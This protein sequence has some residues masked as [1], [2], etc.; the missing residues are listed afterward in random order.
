[1][2]GEV[3]KDDEPNTS[4]EVKASEPGPLLKTKSRSGMIVTVQTEGGSGETNEKDSDSDQPIDWSMNDFDSTNRSWTREILDSINTI[5]FNVGMLVNNSRVQVLIVVLIVINAIMMGIATYDI[6]KKNPEVDAIFEMVDEIFLIIFTVELC[7]QFIYLGWRLPLDGWLL[8]DLI[9]I[10]TSWS[11]ASV[12]IIRA[13]RIF[14]ALRLVTRIKIMKNLLL[15]LFSVMPRMAAIGLM[16]CLIL[17]IFA[18][19]CTQLFKDLHS[20]GLTQF[21]YFGNM[22]A[23]L[24]TLFQMMTLDG[25]GGICREV[26]AVHY[27]AWIPIIAYVI[28]SGFVVVNLIIAVICDAISALGS[29]E[30]AKLEGNYDEDSD[31]DSNS[32]GLEIRAQ[33]DSLEQ[34][35]ED[36]TRIQSRSFH[37]LNYLTKQIEARKKYDEEMKKDL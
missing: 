4:V 18:V 16:L 7:L 36:L 22:F 28:I 8:F 27:W 26:M 6:V 24:L 12:Q 17:Y 25:W 20:K 23:T 13:F 11:F 3:E 32:Q 2:N 34:Q 1:M 37:A 35:M 10:V 21:D 5:R 33:L 29:D 31:L 15:A 19:M 30:K 9:I 14:R